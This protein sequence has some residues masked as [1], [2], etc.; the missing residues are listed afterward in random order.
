[1]ID[2]K[3]K[4]KRL[5]IILLFLII[6]IITSG[7]VVKISAIEKSIKSFAL[8]NIAIKKMN[9]VVVRKNE[10]LLVSLNNSH[11]NITLDSGGIFSRPLISPNNNQVSYLKDNVLYIT[12]NNLEHIRVADNVPQLSFTWQDKNSLLYSP[13]SGK[14]YVYDIVNKISKLY[15]QNEFTYENITLDNSGKIYAEQYLFYKKKRL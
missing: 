14:L 10:L 11:K 4:S 7:F 8:K 2:L 3:I 13:K 5:T 1:M 6:I 9:V 15:L 12:T